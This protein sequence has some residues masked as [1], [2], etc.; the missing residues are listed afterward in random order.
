MILCNVTL[1]F[2]GHI[3]IIIIINSKANMLG[4]LYFS[5]L[6]L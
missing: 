5:F 3:I 1:Q 4:L 6:I 2:P